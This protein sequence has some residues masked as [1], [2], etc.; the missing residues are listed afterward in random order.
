VSGPGDRKH[1]PDHTYAIN[2]F[3]VCLAVYFGKQFDNHGL[4][5]SHGHV[6][7]P[8]MN[9]I[10]PTAWPKL[11]PYTDAPRADLGI[12][13]NFTQIEPI[14]RVFS[15]NASPALVDTFFTAGRLYSRALRS[16]HS[17]PEGAYVDL[18]MCGEI[19]SQFRKFDDEEALYDQQLK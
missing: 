17:D 1:W 4:I 9:N 2:H 8:N 16:C 10:E 6:Q 15:P 14:L 3:L 12:A 11:G 5:E 19:L 7:V 18:V 13:L